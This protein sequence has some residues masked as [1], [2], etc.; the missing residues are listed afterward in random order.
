MEEQLGPSA[1][2]DILI[3]IEIVELEYIRTKDGKPARIQCESV[4]E[5]SIARTVE[6]LPGLGPKLSEEQK[7]ALANSSLE[8]YEAKAPALIEAGTALLGPDG[9]L[10][11]PAFWFTADP[12]NGAIPGRFLRQMDRLRLVKAILRCGCYLGGAADELGFPGGERGRGTNGGGDLESGPGVKD[13]PSSAAS[14]ESVAPAAADKL[15][16][17]GP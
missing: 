12:K 1:L 16:S 11:R 9:Q 2:T 14:A 3:P 13:P 10:I 4:D 6:A 8:R 7:A 5:L 17:P 15:R